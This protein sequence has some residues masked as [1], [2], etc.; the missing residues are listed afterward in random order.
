MTIDS[1]R[2]PS[3]RQLMYNQS[4]LVLGPLSPRLIDKRNIKFKSKDSNIE[5]KL[6]NF[7][8]RKVHFE[9]SDG[10]L[11]L[12]ERNRNTI[13][14]STIVKE[15]A[16]TISNLKNRIRELEE[17]VVTQQTLIK[18]QEEKIATNNQQI[19]VQRL[20]DDLEIAHI[21]PRL[22]LC[23]QVFENNLQ[24]YLFESK[25]TMTKDEFL[26]TMIDKLHIEKNEDA[27]L[28]ANYFIPNGPESI[29]TWKVLEKIIQI[30][31][32]YRSFKDS[33][34]IKLKETFENVEEQKKKQ[35][36]KRLSLLI[37][38][39]ADHMTSKNFTLF[40]QTTDIEF[41][42]RAFIVL[43][44]RKSQSI[45]LISV[46]A[47]KQVMYEIL[48][49]GTKPEKE[50]PEQDIEMNEELSQ[51]AFADNIKK[52]MLTYKVAQAFKAMQHKP[53][54]KAKNNKMAK[55]TKTYIMKTI[56]SGIKD[57]I[58]KFIRGDPL[59]DEEK[60]STDILLTKE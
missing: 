52:I 36:I 10:A 57:K 8:H 11:N 54:L 1:S 6:A 31:G 60:E 26:A 22:R 45:S 14:L 20:R 30:S 37:N 44:L 5:Q 58:K 28:L 55:R 47:L 19:K 59:S 2:L 18:Q 17:E 46:F 32:P 27:L 34:F 56:K 15:Q 50:D 23:L 38:N 25:T 53:K 40:L 24:E 51:T 29:K 4:N 49:F 13:D 12:T 42:I 33:D 35:F 43:L 39:K 9:N 3:S 7:E 48:G 16:L 21:I 41:D